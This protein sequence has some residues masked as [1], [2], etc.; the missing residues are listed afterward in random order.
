MKNCELSSQQMYN[1]LISV[2]PELK[3]WTQKDIIEI[4]KILNKNSIVLEIGC[5]WGRVIKALAPYCKKFIGI[6]NSRVEIKDAKSFLKD[7]KN[8]E[9]FFEDGKKTHFSDEYFDVIVIGGNTFGNLGDNKE[10]VVKE[11]KRI[12]KPNGVILLSVYSEGAKTKRLS[13]YKN[14]GMDI[15]IT[16]SKEI[17]FD[18]GLISE[19]FSKNDLKHIFEKYNLKIQFKEISSIALFCIISK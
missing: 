6:D 1:K 15:K 13:A 10:N 11:M 16:K 14:I 9:V 18:D 12:L 19:E 17:V 3:D 5:S 2:F 8:A 4:K 7:I